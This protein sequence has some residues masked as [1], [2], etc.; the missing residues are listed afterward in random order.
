VIDEFGDL[1]MPSDSLMTTDG[2][3]KADYVAILEDALDR[4]TLQERLEKRL[5]EV[6]HPKTELVAGPVA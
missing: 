1:A 2:A 4:Q 6:L 3:T 5:R